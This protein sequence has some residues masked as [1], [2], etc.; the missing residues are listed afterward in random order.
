MNS[1]N[2]NKECRKEGRQ[3]RKNRKQTRI[4]QIYANSDGEEIAVKERVERRK[5]KLPDGGGVG[6]R[7]Y[8]KAIF[9]L[10]FLIE[11][12][13]GAWKQVAGPEA[14]V[15]RKDRE[16]GSCGKRRLGMR[17][18]TG[19]SGWE[20]VNRTGFYHIG[21]TLTRLFPQDS[22]QVVDFPHLGA[23]RVFRERPKQANT[24]QGSDAGDRLARNAGDIVENAR[25]ARRAGSDLCE[26]NYGLF[27]F[28]SP[29]QVRCPNRLFACAKRGRDCSDCYG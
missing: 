13:K 9:E 24:G 2:E 17:G 27:G 19:L 5:G 21:T 6:L 8:Q 14:S 20:A 16:A 10:R 29:P 12:S 22:T 28:P 15:Q 25:T 1:E 18:F 23:V 4:P 11:S 3:E 7:D 26:K